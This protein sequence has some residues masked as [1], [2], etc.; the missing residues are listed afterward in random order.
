MVLFDG[1][2]ECPPH[3]IPVELALDRTAEG[4]WP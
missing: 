1:G 4:G 3:I 2:Q